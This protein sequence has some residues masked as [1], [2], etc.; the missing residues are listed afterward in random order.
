MAMQPI[1]AAF[2]KQ[3]EWCLRLGSPFTARLM[4]ALAGDI[5]AG[6]PAAA[7]VTPWPGDPLAD[8]LALRVAG[9]LHA[10]VLSGAAPELAALYP[11]AEAPPGALE[12]A[13]PPLLAHHAAML[14]DFLSTAPQTNEVG[15]SGV[16]LGGFLEVAQATRL[17]LRLLEI[18]ASAGLNMGWDRYTYRLGEARWGDPASP[19]QLAPAWTGPLPPLAAPLAVASR[20]GCDIAPVDL[21]DPAQRLRLRAYVWADQRAR[22]TR[23]E[24]ATTLVRAAGW[25]VDS[26][27]AASWLRPRLAQLPTGATTLLYHSIMWQYMPESERHAIEAL[28]SAA[29]ARATPSSPLAW[30]RF[31]PPGTEA[32]PELTLTLWPDGTTRRLALAHPHGQTVQWLA[33]PAA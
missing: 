1:V 26:A 21:E 18:G 10:L 8:A 16:L 23:L 20:E 19:V 5:V 27:P 31:E 4:A 3:E 33:E 32:P 13:L 25:R 28:L 9:G 7:L 6:G 11:P 12:A 15:R 24:A 17:P 2:R 14:R 29:A 22:L 30:L